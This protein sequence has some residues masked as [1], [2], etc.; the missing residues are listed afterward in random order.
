MSAGAAARTQRRGR[1]PAQRGQCTEREV[2]FGTLASETDMC[3]AFALCRPKHRKCAVSLGFRTRYALLSAYGLFAERQRAVLPGAGRVRPSGALAGSTGA[4]SFSAPGSS[5]PPQQKLSGA[6]AALLDEATHLIALN[7]TD[8]AADAAEA[9]AA[10]GAA[11]AAGAEPGRRV[12]PLPLGCLAAVWWHGHRQLL[13]LTAAS[14]AGPACD[15]RAARA[16]GEADAE[17][18]R[19]LIRRTQHPTARA[20]AGASPV[21]P[22]LNPSGWFSALHGLLKPLM[23][24]V[25]SGEGPVLSPRLEMFTGPNCTTRDLRCYFEPLSSCDDAAPCRKPRLWSSAGRRLRRPRLA[26]PREAGCF[27]KVVATSTELTQEVSRAH[28]HDV[29]PAAFAHRGWFWWTAQMLAYVLRPRADLAAEVSAMAERTG[30]AAALREGGVLGMHVRHGDSCLVAERLRTQRTCSPLHDYVRHAR[31]V[32]AVAGT[33]TIY[34]ATDS[35]QVIEQ[36]Q[37]YPEFRW[38]YIHM[39]RGTGRPGGRKVELWDR[40]VWNFHVW[41]QTSVTQ[42][43]MRAATVDLLLLS[44]CTAFVGKFTSNFYR[45]AYALHAA[46][47]EC[48][49]PF[50]SLDAP[51]CFDYGLA[52]GRNWDFPFGE[53]TTG[54]QC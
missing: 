49:A 16:R 20:C 18:A 8:A 34:L 29:I 45:A 51:W 41:G 4:R 14:P 7:A 15:A 30:L 9:G 48:A 36:T 28:A 31:R 25:R 47:C 44:Q 37:R 17:A 3:A 24:A 23:R 10:A 38:L 46:G 32:G 54:L 13:S 50:V 1:A 26:L 21:K 2:A 52:E 22:S 42:A 43:M 53:N 35:A 5:Q 27:D 39:P 6:L 12:P 11:A 19:A 33:R 40:R